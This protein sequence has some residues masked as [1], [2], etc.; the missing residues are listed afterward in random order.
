MTKQLP[1]TAA[2]T[3][4]AF[5]AHHPSSHP[6]EAVAFAQRAFLDTVG[7][8]LLGAERPA[9]RFA[10]EAVM[11]W[12]EGDKPVIG[13]A[14]T[15]PAPWAA[16]VNGTSAHALDF[17]DWEDPGITHASASLVPAILA[18]AAPDT[19]A[20]VLFDAYLVGLEVIM[21]IGEAVNMTH[22]E[23][24]WHTTN[25]L[26]VMGC[27]AACARLHRLDARTSMN[28]V[29]LST[30]MMGGFTSQFGTTTKPMHAGLAAKSGIV[31]AQIAA[32][33]ATAQAAVMESDAGF[34]NA[35]TKCTASELAERLALLGK[36]L[37]VL[38]LG[39]HNKKYPSCSCTHLVLE[40]CLMLR[41]AH[42]LKPEDIAH[43]EGCISDIAFSVLPYG[44]PESGN[45]GLFSVPWCAAAALIDGKVTIETFSEAS[46]R[47][48]DLRALAAR[49]SVTQH[50]RFP[51]LAFH[52]DHPDITRITLVSGEVLEQP[53]AFPIG[54]PRRP[55]SNEE[56]AEK[57]HAC[58]NSQIP[59]ESAEATCALLLGQTTDWRLGALT[60]LVTHDEEQA[61]PMARV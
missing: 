1:E 9:T 2:A 21:R 23:L 24:G 42:G 28:A 60:S 8:M 53:I 54:G 58:A 57:F 27:A 15:L 6:A 3:I 38:H 22:Y 26:S 31:A 49:V 4:G 10:L 29:S 50:P 18:E 56:L 43:V 41:E 30:S 19:P 32:T 14:L 44:V 48:E 33:G 20:S 17:D 51:G 13:T 35:M 40:G 16:L 34:L 12:G 55:L 5:I 61:K 11:P 25:T 7:C 45:E 52:E 59:R 37:S 39:M 46:I 47:R 36:P